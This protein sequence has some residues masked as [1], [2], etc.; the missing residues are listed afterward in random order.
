MYELK[1][2]KLPEMLFRRKF[3]HFSATKTISQPA[4]S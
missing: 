3:I 1:G 4:L 2:K